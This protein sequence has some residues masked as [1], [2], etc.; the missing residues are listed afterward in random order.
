VI[1]SCQF[2]CLSYNSHNRDIKLVYIFLPKGFVIAWF[3]GKL[4]IFE[5]DIKIRKIF[6]VDFSR[7]FGQ[8]RVLREK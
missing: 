4:S 8:N 3:H 2:V 1:T 5:D 6:M 7:F